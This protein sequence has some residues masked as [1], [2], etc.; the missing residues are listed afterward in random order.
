MKKKMLTLLISGVMVLSLVGCGDKNKEKVSNGENISVTEDQD[1]DTENGDKEGRNDSEVTTEY[2][3]L[4]KIGVNDFNKQVVGKFEELLKSKGFE[5]EVSEKRKEN[6]TQEG[7]C[8]VRYKPLSDG[9]EPCYGGINY[10][11]SAYPGVAKLGYDFYYFV[12]GEKIKNGEQKMPEVKDLLIQE[13]YKIL[14]GNEMSSETINK[15]N[16]I[17]TEAYL[18]GV[19]EDEI[20]VEVSGPFKVTVSTT[21]GD[22]TF[23]IMSSGKGE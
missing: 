8:N 7:I 13:P 23:S 22:L 10:A 1:K 17:F 18:D 2:K 11:A 3:P 21:N 9:E 19:H 16:K 5:V 4:D 14:T 15:I 20:I 6:Q 12:E